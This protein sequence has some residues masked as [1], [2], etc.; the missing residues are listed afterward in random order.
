MSNVYNCYRYAKHSSLKTGQ[1]VALINGVSRSLIA[2]LGAAEI[3]R[4]EDFNSPENLQVMQEVYIAYIEGFFITHSVEVALEAVRLCHN[5]GVV[6]VFNIC[7]VYVADICPEALTTVARA[8]DIV[9]G[10]KEEF[11]SLANILKIK[12]NVCDEMAVNLHCVLWEDNYRGTF[13]LNQMGGFGKTL[14][15]TQGSDAVL[16]VCGDRSLVKYN[17]PYLDPKRIKD[18]TGAG[19]TFAAGFLVA[20]LQDKPLIGCLAF[21][22]SVAQEV[23]QNIGVDLCSWQLK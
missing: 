21:G 20:L 6:V 8:A 15:I 18:P 5:H 13:K 14:I 4:L 1:A 9:I 12:R 7:G 19:D 16:C 23:I 3:Y 17:A 11:M 22:C 2:H 10:N